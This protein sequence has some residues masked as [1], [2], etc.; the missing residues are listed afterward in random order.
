M[1]NAVLSPAHFAHELGPF[2]AAVALEK[3]VKFAASS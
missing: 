3:L 2:Y 1:N